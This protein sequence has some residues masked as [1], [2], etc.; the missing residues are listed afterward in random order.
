MLKKDFERYYSNT[1]GSKLKRLLNC[2]RIP[3][4]D[5][6]ITF[7]FGQWLLKKNILVRFF[8]T[9]F[10][11]FQNYRIRS[12]WGIGLSRRSDIGEGFYI[13]HY[14]SIFV[15]ANA[16]LGKNVSISQGVTIGVSGKGDKRGC[17]IIGNNV[18]IAPGAK[19]FGKIKIG[20]NVKIGA[21]AVVYKDIPDNSV[22]VSDGLKIIPVKR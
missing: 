18:Y 12:N 3:G 16:K 20:N 11:F 22:V 8:L 5:A 10:Y 21:N 14:G 7:R 9:P 6:I 17:P 1:K 2:F 19:I 13:G 15:A 4:L